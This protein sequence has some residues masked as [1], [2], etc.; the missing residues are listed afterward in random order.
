VKS[1]ATLLLF[2]ALALPG[3]GGA[4]SPVDQLAA[5]QAAVRAAEEAGGD[6]DPEAL[7]YLKLARES[8][9]KAKAN[10][11]QENNEIALRLLK[12]A[13]AD[14]DLAR[15]IARKLTAEAE[16]EE[17]KKMLAKLKPVTK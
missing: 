2:L 3:C 11:E 17:A 8:L 16:A 5:S 14:A 10:M 4:P 9:E 15:G 6:K 7:L 1:T 12:K 13:E